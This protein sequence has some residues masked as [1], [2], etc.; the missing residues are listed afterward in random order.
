MEVD[1]WKGPEA[2][3]TGRIIDSYTGQNLVMDHNDWQIRIWERSW[4]GEA[5][6]NN[7]SLAV[8][9]DGTYNNDKLFAGTYD[10]LPYDGPF[11]PVD[12]IKGVVLNNGKKATQDFT[13]T[14]YLQVIDFETKLTTMQYAGETWPALTMRCRLRAPIREGLPNLYWVRP[15]I[16]ELKN[17]C[18]NSNNIGINEYNNN[19][20]IEINRSWAND[21]SQRFGITE[22]TEVSGWYEISPMPLKQGRTYYVRMGAAVNV[23]SQRYNYSPI[24]QI[25]VPN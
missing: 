5:E 9:N 15:F 19:V 24:V 1:N 22:D 7:Q 11:W 12:T 2:G 3:V 6:V 8:K 10:M 21:M 16:S 13:V 14:P 25:D 20:R 18:G 17:F 4:E 23:L